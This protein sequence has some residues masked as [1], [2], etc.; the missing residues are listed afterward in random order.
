MLNSELNYSVIFS[1]LQSSHLLLRWQLC[2][3]LD[4]LSASWIRQPVFSLQH[5]YSQ[6]SCLNV[7]LRR[8]PVDIVCVCVYC[9]FCSVRSESSPSF[10]RV[11]VL[12]VPPFLPLVHIQCGEATDWMWQQQ[13]VC[14]TVVLDSDIVAV[15]PCNL[16]STPFCSRKNT[17]HFWRYFYYK[18]AAPFEAVGVSVLLFWSL[19]H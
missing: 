9:I 15:K 12:R 13:L 14:G 18:P 1:I 17:W 10:L 11:F 19:R 5:G 8:Q 2:S 4:S 16:T 6:F 3:L 7:L